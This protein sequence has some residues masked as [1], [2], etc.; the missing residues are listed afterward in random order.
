MYAFGEKTQEL[1]EPADFL[2]QGQWRSSGMLCWS[3]LVY[4]PPRLVAHFENDPSPYLPTVK[5]V[6]EDDHLSLA[7]LPTSQ[8]D[9]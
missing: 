3:L 7:V 9:A 6:V 1:G 2:R 4:L 8:M 5:H